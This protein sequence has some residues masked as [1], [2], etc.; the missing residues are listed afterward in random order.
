MP[1]VRVHLQLPETR[2]D[3]HPRTLLPAMSATG[4]ALILLAPIGLAETPIEAWHFGSGNRLLLAQSA[5]VKAN[6]TTLEF[7]IAA[8]PLSSA[9][10]QFGRQSGV[11][12][13]ADTALVS[14]R[15]AAA[16]SG[17]LTLRQALEQLL[18][19]SGLAYRFGD[20]GT[21]TLVQ[22]VAEQRSGPIQLAP[23]LVQGELQTRTLQD[24]QT[25]VAVITGDD[26]DRRSDNDFTTVVERTP[27]ITQ[28]AGNQSIAIRGIPAFGFAAGRGNGLTV[29]NTID[30][31]TLSN[32]PFLDT[33]FPKSTW[34]LEQIE[35]LRGPQS[36]QTG[37]NALAGAIVTR[38]RDPIHDFE[39]KLRGELANMDTRGGAFSLNVPISEDLLAVRLSGDFRRSD[40]F[41]ENITLGDKDAGSSEA[42]TLRAGILFEPTDQLSAT[43][44]LFRIDGESNE[45]EVDGDRFSSQREVESDVPFV[46][47]SEVNSASLELVY[48]LDTEF[49]IVSKTTYFEADT[50]SIEDADFTSAS[51][52]AFNRE[53]DGRNFEQEL[54]LAYE[55][56]RTSGVIGGFF[57]DIDTDSET[58]STAGTPTG[59]FVD[60][61]VQ[62][63]AVFGEVEA[64]VLSDLRLIAGF[65]YD[66]EKATTR[67]VNI[68]GGGT[69]TV[70]DEDT[71]FSAFLPKLGFVYDLTDDLSLGFTAQRGYRAGGVTANFSGGVNEFDPEKTWN[72][73][74]SLR[75]QW[76]DDRLTVNA[77][78]FYTKWRDQQVLQIVP[79]GPPFFFDIEVTNA[80]ESRLFGGEIDVT[81]RPTKNLELFAS[82]A[83]VDTKFIEFLAFGQ[84]FS[85]NEFQHAPRYTAAAGGTYDFVNGFFVGADVSYTDNSFSDTANEV[86]IDSRFLVNAR[87]GYRADNFEVIAYAR[88][89]LD[90]DYALQRQVN[91][92]GVVVEPGEPLTFGVIGQVRF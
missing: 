76:F 77:N 48:D 7:S 63:Y 5:D 83:V 30:G 31:A 20:D 32:L 13:V 74:G 56:N 37:R 86:E 80:G 70:F 40:G 16:V 72:F 71:T 10:I 3:T 44:K 82:G 45:V 42:D 27:G 21:V 33:R 49:S 14:G 8:Q 62:N 73:E 66:Q 89:L 38:S 36:T 91:G 87:A 53:R 58:I 2:I 39:F 18:A 75:S 50:F 88:N 22:A 85:D 34:D 54:R 19:G 47:E 61:E 67:S 84:D 26:L 78:V 29:S 65:R 24:T 28:A 15:E 57:A 59:L 68:I 81:A 4:L 25:S 55:G 43:L 90:K 1:A 64:E 92:A 23:I 41:I 79:A 51:L 11:Q 52:G 46:L 60:D 69:P 9:L 12:V 35:I 17:N 6:T